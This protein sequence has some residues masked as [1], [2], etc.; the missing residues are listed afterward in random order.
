MVTESQSKESIVSK[1]F[2]RPVRLTNSETGCRAI[3]KAAAGGHVPSRR[4]IETTLAA[5]RAAFAPL[6]RADAELAVLVFAASAAIFQQRANG[7]PPGSKT[8]ERFWLRTRYLVAGG[9]GRQRLDF[10]AF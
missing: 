6:R 8:T 10:F 5:C 4:A 2:P 9:L 1:R 7:R 3:Y